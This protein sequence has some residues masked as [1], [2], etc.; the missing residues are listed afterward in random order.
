MRTRLVSC[1]LALAA[2]ACVTPTGTSDRALTPPAT[3]V[4]AVEDSYHGVT[5][6]DPY[7]WLE[8]SKDTA[9]TAW[10]S[11][12]TAHARGYLDAL[13]GR[14]ALSQRLRELLGAKQVS[15]G[16]LKVAGG[17]VFALK[18]Q[19]P[20]PQRLLVVMPAVDAP[21]RAEVVL[22]PATLDASGTTTIDWYRPSPDGKRVAVSVSKG[23]SESGDVILYD[24]ETKAQVLETITRVNGGTAGGDLAWAPDGRSFYYTRYPRPG[25]RSAEDAAFYVQIYRHVLGTDPATDTYEL[26]KDFVRI[27]EIMLEVEPSSGLVLATVQNGDGGEF[28][29][30][31][32]SPEGKWTTFTRYADKIVQASFGRP[33]QLMLVSRQGAP[34]GKLL[35]LDVRGLDLAKAQVLVPEDEATLVTDFWG[36]PTVVSTA[37]RLLVSYQL[38]GP[39]EVRVFDHAGKRLGVLGP[40]GAVADVTMLTVLEGDVV[41]T[42]RASYVEPRTLYRVDAVSGAETALPLTAK[43]LVDLSG[44]EVVRELATSKDGTKVP[45]NITIKKGT[46]LDGSAACVVTGY[47]GF[48]VSM[49]PSFPL[50]D[51]VLLERGVILVEANLRGGGEF[52]AAWHDGGRLTQKQHVFDDMIAVVE[53]LAA[54]K[55]TSAARTGIIGGSNGGLLMGAVLTQRPELVRA[56]VSSV[57]I[58]DML[59]VELSSNGAFNVPEFG[60][61]KDEAQFRAMYAYSPYHRVVDG[62]RYPAV[63]FQTG[64][65]DPRVDPMQSR[66]MTARLQAAVAGASPVLLATST[67]AGHGMGTS[68]DERIATLVDAFVF[69]MAELGVR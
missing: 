57:G 60:T 31:L 55:Y 11:A 13:A 44:Y 48:G 18:F 51:S 23:G 46:V 15:H 59:R 66:K 26:G 56:V 21:E 35:T 52:G 36:A 5:V 54:R 20:K 2:A 43:P 67:S 50:V 25:E 61:V 49:T 42:S 24:V 68:L 32:R 17:R 9:V 1:A 10:S 7:R 58:Y 27:A 8:D 30:H 40:S 34:R 65:N 14:E 45:L 19:P 62:T 37:S 63:L 12:Q 22:D 41:L 38:G 6:A 47:G 3:E 28:E 69:L 4:R 39:S 29:H 33:G 16:G 64:E 53:H